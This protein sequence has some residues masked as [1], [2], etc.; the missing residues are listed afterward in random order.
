MGWSYDETQLTVSPR[1]AVR[2]NIGDTDKADPQLQDEEIDYLITQ[3]TSVGAAAYHACLKIA[4]R[5]AKKANRTIGSLSIQYRDKYEAYLQLAEE[6]RTELII[7]NIGLPTA[8]GY[9]TNGEGIL[10][11]R[12]PDENVRPDPITQDG[13]PN[14]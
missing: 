6:I 14:V 7:R 2:F 11:M 4:A 3:Y 13:Q 12:D 9:V 8:G 10:L 5:W 1:D